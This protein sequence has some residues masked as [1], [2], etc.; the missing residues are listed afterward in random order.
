[1]VLQKGSLLDALQYTDMFVSI[2]FIAMLMMPITR[3]FDITVTCIK[4]MMINSI[5][6]YPWGVN[7]KQ[8]GALLHS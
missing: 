5:A 1:M 7:V 6:E 2:M 3:S 8:I 4:I